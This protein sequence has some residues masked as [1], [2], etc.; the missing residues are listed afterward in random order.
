MENDNI[1]FKKGIL[2][3]VPFLVSHLLDIMQGFFI[4]YRKAADRPPPTVTPQC[5]NAVNAPPPVAVVTMR[6][7]LTGTGN[8]YRVQPLPGVC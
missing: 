8:T 1:T 5:S 7:Y 2:Y 3:R 4:R 6:Q